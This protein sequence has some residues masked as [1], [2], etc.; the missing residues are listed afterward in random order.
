MQMKLRKKQE[1]FDQFSAISGL[2]VSLRSVTVIKLFF[3][4]NEPNFFVR[5]ELLAPRLSA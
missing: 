5:G 3:A 2:A 1:K 4:Q